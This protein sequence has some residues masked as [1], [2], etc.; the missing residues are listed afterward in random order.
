MNRVR[1]SLVVLVTLLAT[2]VTTF[3]QRAEQRQR[4]RQTTQARLEAIEALQKELAKLKTSLEAENQNRVDWRQLPAEERAK[5]FEAFWQRRQEQN[6]MIATLERE[7]AKLKGLRELRS[8]HEEFIEKLTALKELAVKEK[9]DLT[10]ECLEELMKA[11]EKAFAERMQELTSGALTIPQPESRSADGKLDPLSKFIPGEIWPDNNGV[12]INAHGGGVLFHEGSYYW[13]GEH[14][15]AGRGGN[16]ANVGVH[17]YSSTDLLHWK[18]EGIALR[19]V[20][21]PASDI[22]R[23]CILERPKVIYNA[24][25]GK[26]V[27]WF[28]LEL[29]GQGY[30]AARTGVAVSD[31]PTGPYAFI[32]SLRPHAKVWPENFNPKQPSDSEQEEGALAIR[33][34][35]LLRR[36]FESGQM[37]RDMTLFVDDDGKAYHIHAAEDNY[38]LHISQLSD[39]YLSFSGRYIRV[40]PGGHN[41]APAVFKRKRKYYLLTSGCT[42]WAPNA[43]RSAVADSI[44]GPWKSLPNPCVGVNPK[45]IMGPEKTFGGQS[46]FVLPV[47]GKRDVFI[48][49]FDMWRPRNAID[50]RYLWLPIRFGGNG[51]E[52]LWRKTWDLSVFGIEEPMEET[53]PSLS[54]GKTKNADEAARNFQL[55]WADEF[56]TDG[57]PDPKHWTYENGFVR[58][59]ELQWYQPENARCE[60]GLLIIEGRRE[61]KANPSYRADSTSWKRN[62]EYVNYTSA[63]LKTMGLH[64]WTYGRFEMRGRIDTRPGLWPAFWTLGSARGWP[65]CGEIDIMEYY[66]GEL[67]ANAC[68]ASGRRWRPVWDTVKVPIT[69]FSDPDWSAKF[70]VWRMDWNEDTIKLYVDDTLLNTIE[71]DKTLNNDREK[72]N[73]FHEPHY[74][75][76]NL[77]IGGTNG[78]DPAMTEFPARFEVDYVRV[79]KI[80][81][82]KS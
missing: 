62:R 46:T 60:N 44:W 13:F 34:G 78:G 18:D 8:E 32:R 26:Y 57:R 81:S 36:D 54:E 14:K 69:Q 6:Q 5:M 11:R 63:C 22:T 35:R 28:H 39:D 82:P 42:G 33:Q 31:T 64:Q 67:L 29:R 38:T 50:G 23:G 71:L 58:N 65:G 66:R 61:R 55:V 75:L 76:L 25:T 19:V 68:W 40:L 20:D 74:M 48:A 2:T 4:G 51:F 41:E 27:M 56:N 72:A 15:T 17:C 80:L 12:H 52:I 1:I 10:A 73:P 47:P 43:A 49:M 45:N 24:Q 3:S 30:D 21:D 16:Q 77:A 59:E 79:Y 53:P 7:I 70:H 37:S 9:A